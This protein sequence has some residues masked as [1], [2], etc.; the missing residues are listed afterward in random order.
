MKL[1]SASARMLLPRSVIEVKQPSA[2]NAALA[3]ELGN[4]G[5][6]LEE[7]QTSLKEAKE[8]NRVL[9]DER[10]RWKDA[11][12]LCATQ[13]KGLK[14]QLA[15]L[16][17]Q[18]AADVN[19]LRTQ[20]VEKDTYISNIEQSH[21]NTTAADTQ[22]RDQLTKDTEKSRTAMEGEL[23]KYRTALTEKK[24]EFASLQR[25]LAA[26]IQ[27][28]LQPIGG[29]R[30]S[31][32]QK[33]ILPAIPTSGRRSSKSGGDSSSGSIGIEDA[34]D[35]LVERLQAEN[36]E[37][38]QRLST[39][40][41]QIRDLSSNL[42]AK[43]DV[44][45][46][47]GRSKA[48]DGGVGG[49]GGKADAQSASP[50]GSARGRSPVSDRDRDRD[51]A[52][53]SSS[54]AS[55]SS[56]ARVSPAR[57]PLSPRS[58]KSSRSSFDRQGRRL[59]KT[60]MAA[61]LGSDM[62]TAIAATAALESLRPALHLSNERETSASQGGESSDIFIPTV[63]K[64]SAT[65]IGAAEEGGTMVTD[66]SDASA[67]IGTAASS[68]AANAASNMSG[69]AR[70]PSFLAWQENSIST[71]DSSTNNSTSRRRQSTAK[72]WTKKEFDYTTLLKSPEV[73]FI[74]CNDC[75]W[76]HQSGMNKLKLDATSAITTLMQEVDCLANE[77][78]R[79]E[80]DKKKAV[81]YIFTLESKL[82][83]A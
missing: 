34:K 60:N 21:R 19:R 74:F 39:C 59:S 31:N 14:E 58:D 23:E 35:K 50:C 36:E 37:L 6:A 56:P 11:E 78:H 66:V 68:I 17:L 18:A 16:K 83:R 27:L 42:R 2:T 7:L 28:P 51:A 22:A 12:A 1:N 71:V 82:Q 43:N 47:E 45:V 33:L 54:T 73:E 40:E 61:S 41:A 79:A 67:A 32:P 63:R 81:D 75:A 44:S 62:D 5:D 53:S 70:R 29:R 4:S 8:K 77:M 55:V 65:N 15:E 64:G 20:L 49:G 46:V 3:E 69:T 38:K 26:V 9:E 30:D 76:H 25:E 52:S 13:I 10:T 80:A 57:P 72:E 24:V 48:G